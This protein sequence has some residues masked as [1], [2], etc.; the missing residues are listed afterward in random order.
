M[1]EEGYDRGRQEGREDSESDC[2]A[3][4]QAAEEQAMIDVADA[5]ADTLTEIRDEIDT[6]GNRAWPAND[7]NCAFDDLC[8]VHVFLG[9]IGVCYPSRLL[10]S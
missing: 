3:R 7:D 2:T 6:C 5:R 10:N 8:V 4:L 1:Y 9:L